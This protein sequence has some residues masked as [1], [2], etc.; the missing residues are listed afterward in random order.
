MNRL[1]SA[2][3]FGAVVVS[4]LDLGAQSN[5]TKTA[6]SNEWPTYGHDPGGM[7]FSPVTQINAGQCQPI[8]G[9]VGLPHAACGAGSGTCRRRS[10]PRRGSGRGGARRRRRAGRGRGRGGSGF[11]SG[12]TTPLV[13]NGVMYIA[14]PYDRVVAL[15]PTTGRRC[16]CFSCRRATRRRAASSTG[17]ATRRRRRRSCSARATAGCSRSTR[18]PG[19][20]TRR[21]ARRAA[22][23]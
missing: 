9:R 5:A 14:T 13:V 16:G 6:A 4:T 22:S 11:A 7:R 19:S 17:R 8:T 1:A 23:I 20:Q 12:Q 3:V 10:R 15:D 18:R 21:S 2:L